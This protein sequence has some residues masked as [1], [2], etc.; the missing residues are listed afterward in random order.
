MPFLSPPMHSD[1][2]NSVLSPWCLLLSVLFFPMCFLWDLLVLI[3]FQGV[4]QAHWEGTKPPWELQLCCNSFFRTQHWQGEK[5]IL[6]KN[7]KHVQ[8]FHFFVVRPSGSCCHIPYARNWDRLPGAPWGGGS[9][10]FVSLTVHLED[11]GVQ[12]AFILL[13]SFNV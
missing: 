4:L 9:S 11:P 5:K 12:A 3:F 13:I 7:T 10:C 8:C 6:W 1:S 2:E